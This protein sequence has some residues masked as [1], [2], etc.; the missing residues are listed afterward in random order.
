MAAVPFVEDL[1]TELVGER[2]K[3]TKAKRAVKQTSAAIEAR[4]LRESWEALRI[5]LRDKLVSRKGAAIPGLGRFTWQVL[6]GFS[7]DDLDP[8][9]GDARDPS[10]YFR[11][12]VLRFATDV[13]RG[14]HTHGDAASISQ[15]GPER[16]GS[17]PAGA[18]ERA[19]EARL[20]VLRALLQDARAPLARAARGQARRVL[21]PGLFA[22]GAPAKRPGGK[23]VRGGDA[24]VIPRRR[25]RDADA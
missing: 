16:H 5:W 20:P 18:A 2:L 10:G 22:S 3:T 25:G 21:R 7:P 1:I 19:A 4:K 23:G 11:S 15:N 24:A 9:N 12:S 17:A 6:G 13:K 14:W 8:K